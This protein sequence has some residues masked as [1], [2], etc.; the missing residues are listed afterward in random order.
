MAVLA[1]RCPILCFNVGFGDTSVKG[2]AKEEDVNCLTHDIIYR[3]EDNIRDM[4]LNKLPKI[5]VLEKKVMICSFQVND[6]FTDVN[7]A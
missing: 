2:Y 3:L 7:F 6:G 4:I 1:S 5:P